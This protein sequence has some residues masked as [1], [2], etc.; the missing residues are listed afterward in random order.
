MLKPTKTARRRNDT[1]FDDQSTQQFGRRKK[2]ETKPVAETF[3][4]ELEQIKEN[5]RELKGTN[6]VFYDSIVNRIENNCRALKDLREE[7]TV[8]R[9]RLT[10]L[11]AIRKSF[12]HH[13]KDLDAVIKRNLRYVNKLQR[14]IDSIKHDK[15][16]AI[17][18]Q[19]ELRLI[20]ESI[21]NARDAGHPELVTIADIKNKL[22]KANIKVEETKHLV[23]L[24]AR[25]IELFEKQRMKWDPLLK[26]RQDS[27]IKKDRDISELYLIARDSKH[28]Q[29]SAHNQY[30]QTE[31]MVNEAINNRE[32]KLEQKEMQ[33]RAATAYHRQDLVQ[34]DTQRIT[35]RSI[36]SQSS[37]LR[38]RANKASRELKE[39]QNR[40]CQ[41]KLDAIYE[42]FNT[43]D[44]S[45]IEKMFTERENNAR[46]LN[47]QID[48]LKQDI[49]MLKHKSDI[50]KVE[51]EEKEFTQARGVGGNRLLAEGSTLQAEKVQELAHIK[52]T[53]EAFYEH[54]KTVEAGCYHIQDILSLVTVN[55]EQSSDPI[56]IL[57]WS[58]EKAREV[59]LILE[60]ND[61]SLCNIINRHVYAQTRQ[62]N[63]GLDLTKMDS[64]KRNA[65]QA[66][67][68]V[69]KRHPR[70]NKNDDS[71]RVL[72]RN[73]VK[74]L[75]Q[76]AVQNQQQ[77]KKLPTLR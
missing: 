20:L 49:K 15:E 67:K 59:K 22:D 68:D 66:A 60:E 48:E 37:F 62:A 64:S 63:Q 4:K 41:A 69:F 45:E 74:I 14:Q 55:E 12:N 57:K 21:E 6:K 30:T 16:A 25:I 36:T 28:S 3:E 72:D 42:V 73:M 17:R 61:E 1:S 27:V 10:E 19:D 38:N 24:Y 53:I 5:A 13:S 8:L 54:Q 33:Y 50:L 9:G 46:S 51:I 65:K 77:N 47:K 31:R 44:P 11:V 76:K 2:E 70:E 43:I 18:R 58:L 7:H 39:E 71:S 34:D 56:E 75:A 35:Q 29:V 26:E 40:R 23:K 52:R 32:R